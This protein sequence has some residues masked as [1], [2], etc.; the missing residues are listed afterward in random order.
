MY[1]K[2]LNKKQLFLSRN[3]SFLKDHQFYLAGGTA[4]ALHLGHRTSWDFDFY[5]EKEFESKKLL[6]EIKKNFKNFKDIKFAKN[7]VILDINGIHAS[8]FHYP[9]KLLKPFVSFKTLSL[10][11]VEDIAAMKLIAIVQRGTKRDFIDIYFL[12]LRHSLKDLI[13]W[14]LKK[15]RGYSQILILKALL[16]FEDAEKERYKRGIDIFDKRVDWQVVKKGIFEKVKAY[17]L[18]MFKK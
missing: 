1:L 8:F 12:L 18:A 10:V 4:L 3:L 2:V 6:E 16:Y 13:G 11:S 14:A 5:T 17:Q 9:Y 15:Y 7:T